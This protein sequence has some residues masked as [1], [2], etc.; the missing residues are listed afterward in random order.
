[1]ILLHYISDYFTGE[2]INQAA[3]YHVRYGL[4]GA[5]IYE[6]MDLIVKS[7]LVLM[8][9]SL[10]LLYIIVKIK[11]YPNRSHSK[12][13]FIISY[14]FI[15]VSFVFHPATIDAYKL[16]DKYSDVEASESD[17][18][19]YYRSN[20]VKEV[21]QKDRNFVFIYLEGFERTY[22]NEQLF[23]DLVVGLKKLETEGI[24]FTNIGQTTNAGWTIAGMVASQCGLPLFAPSSGNSMSGMDLFLPE[25]VCLG[26]LLAGEGY[27]LEYYGGSDLNFAGKG[28]FYK[29]H[30][31]DKVLG[32]KELQPRLI[33]PDY[34]SNWGLYDDSLFDQ[35][36][37]QYL[38]LSRRG[39]KFGLFLLTLDT[40]HPD[41]HPSAS[42][43]DLVYQDGANPI[44]NAVSCADRLASRFVERIR[45]SN[46]SDNTVIVIV[47]DH[48]AL[49][50]SASARLENGERKNLFFV[51][52][53]AQRE[54]KRVDK[55]GTTLDIASTLL[56]FLGYRG[57][58]GL[59]R[60]LLSDAISLEE[61]LDDLDSQ[62]LGWRPLIEEFWAFPSIEQGVTINAGEG[63]LVIDN[64][65]FGIPAL[66]RL[67]SRL[68]TEIMFEFN[69]SPGHKNLYE[70][71]KDF[72]S[73][74][75]FL[76]VDKCKRIS[77][78]SSVKIDNGTCLAIGRLDATS[79]RKRINGKIFPVAQDVTINKNEIKEILF[80]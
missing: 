52:D 23:P 32:L 39:E 43:A 65:R 24:T 68:E 78:V 75:P 28:K 29:T 9:N 17:F 6:Y 25:A 20:I 1:M 35:A 57:E 11:F 10:V 21:P 3:I 51:L 50:N 63:V 77:T 58:I 56:P 53:P 80:N 22:F 26:D 61:H 45:K 67:N 49:R 5:G 42:C 66:I 40:H 18:S 69:A 46:Y 31:F 79:D 55:Q 4:R 33:N 62:L 13:K 44:L 12:R 72:D 36:F 74:S 70:L 76:W 73:I 30:Q 7:V 41:G 16:Y 34:V 19:D 14:S 60:D 48:L 37:D 59:G 71:F 27:H 15:L 38:E 2:G 8:L 64:R 47:S 54:E